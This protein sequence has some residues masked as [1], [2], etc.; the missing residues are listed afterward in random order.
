[1]SLTQSHADDDQKKKQNQKKMR[2]KALRSLATNVGEELDSEELQP[3]QLPRSP[4]FSNSTKPRKISVSEVDL[5]TIEDDERLFPKFDLFSTHAERRPDSIA[6]SL[7]RQSKATGSTTKQKRS[8]ETF[9]GSQGQM[10]R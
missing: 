7:S 10:L 1:M 9:N 6:G 8:D 4:L 5:G 2:A 3:G